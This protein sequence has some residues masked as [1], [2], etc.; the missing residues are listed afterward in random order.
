LRVHS[1]RNELVV[2]LQPASKNMSMEAEVT[3]VIHHQ[4][5]TGEVIA[6]REDS[7]CCS[8]L[9]TVCERVILL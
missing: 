5:M 8:E 4:A 9:Q 2:R 6:D 7:T 3:V 1:W